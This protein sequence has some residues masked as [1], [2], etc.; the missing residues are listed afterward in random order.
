MCDMSWKA[1]NKY[2]P[3]LLAMLQLQLAYI[4]ACIL[5]TASSTL[6]KLMSTYAKDK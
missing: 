3:S 5:N 6:Q 2:E 1:E 4:Y